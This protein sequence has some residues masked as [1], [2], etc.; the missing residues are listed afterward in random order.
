MSNIESDVRQLS[1]WLN[2]EQTAPID[3]N[4]LARVLAL[5]VKQEGHSNFCPQ[6]EALARELKAAKQEKGEPVGYLEIDDI[7]SQRE[8]PHNCRS[9]NL[10]YEAGEGLSPV[11]TTPQQRKPLTDEQAEFESVFKLPANCTKFEGGYAPTSYNAWDAQTFCA[12]WEGWKA[13]AAH[14]ISPQGARHDQ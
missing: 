4:A 8:Y 3:R 10:W 13:R 1:K 6:C 12:R 11:Y 2:E 5:H 9:V 7:E 14:G